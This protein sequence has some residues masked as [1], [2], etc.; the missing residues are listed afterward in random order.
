[1]KRLPGATK[2]DAL[3]EEYYLVTQAF[4]KS[5]GGYRSR[6]RIVQVGASQQLCVSF[7]FLH[8]P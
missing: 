1:M 3:S 8:I 2:L 7:F 4:S 5:M 6:M